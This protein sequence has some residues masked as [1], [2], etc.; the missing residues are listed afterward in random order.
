MIRRKQESFPAGGHATMRMIDE[1][2]S[3]LGIEKYNWKGIL[4]TRYVW[5]RNEI[6]TILLFEA[7]QREKENH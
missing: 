5:A 2:L 6:F 1:L 3:K 7:K 4:S